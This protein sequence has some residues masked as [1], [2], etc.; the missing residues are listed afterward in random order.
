M[1]IVAGF[2]MLGSYGLVVNLVPWDFSKLLGVYVAAF[3]TVAVLFGRFLFGENVPWSTLTGLA[4][5][6]AGAG[7]IQLGQV[8]GK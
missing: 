7:V 1:L 5:I 6:V 4:V 3:A 8:L 2:A